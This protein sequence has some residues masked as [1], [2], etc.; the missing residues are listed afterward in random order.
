MIDQPLSISPSLEENLLGSGIATPLDSGPRGTTIKQAITIWE[1]KHSKKASEAKEV[2]LEQIMPPI[3]NMDATLLTLT[4]CEEL[5]LSTN[6][7]EKISLQGLKNLKI[8]SLGRNNIKNLNGLEAVGDTLEELRISYNQIEG[9]KGVHVLKKLKILLMNNNQVKDWSEFNKLQ[10]LPVL[11]EL[12]FVGN[13]LEEKHS[14]DGDWQER[15]K[16]S[17]K[18]LKKLDGT[19]V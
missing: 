11:M 19:P 3:E 18:R 13:P 17:L 16:K 14:E 15:V 2:K 4:L 10:N 9:L 7:I 1:K 8:L 6:A 5:S 12:E